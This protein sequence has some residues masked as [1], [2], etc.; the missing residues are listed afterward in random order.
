MQVSRRRLHPGRYVA[1]DCLNGRD[2]CRIQ[3]R[4]RAGLVRV[5]RYDRS[6]ARAVQVRRRLHEAL[7]FG[8]CEM[9]EFLTPD[10]AISDGLRIAAL[11]ETADAR[12]AFRAAAE[13]A[14][15]LIGD[16]DRVPKPKPMK[17]KR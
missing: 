14:G 8:R 15:I 16:V 13:E 6:A 17:R 5:G 10:M 12:Q 7:D 11:G 9:G 4:Q 2:D 1:C 3:F